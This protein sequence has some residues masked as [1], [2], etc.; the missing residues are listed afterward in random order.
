MNDIATVKTYLPLFTGFYGSLFGDII[1]D[2]IANEI[3]AYNEQNNTKL[4]YD[5]FDYNVSELTTKITKDSTE[6]VE[7]YISDNLLKCSVKFE[8]LVSPRYYNYTNDSINIE[9]NFNKSEFFILIDENKAELINLIEDS[10][11]GYDGFIPTHSSDINDWI[12]E[13]KKDFE[14]CEHKVGALFDFLLQI[15]DLT[16]ETLYQDLIMEKEYFIELTLT[17]S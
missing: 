3:E 13:L 8:E 9:M 16:R 17:R 14:N 6:I 2:A 5:N 11:T 1:E 10:Y 7:R 12:S 15:K 4:G